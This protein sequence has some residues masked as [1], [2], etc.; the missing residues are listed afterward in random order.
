[1]Q[2]QAIGDR[3]TK[4]N[5]EVKKTRDAL[6]MFKQMRVQPGHENQMRN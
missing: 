5:N 6:H 4:I 2:R 1:M 3:L